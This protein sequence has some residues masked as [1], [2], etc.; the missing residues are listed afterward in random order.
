MQINGAVRA[1]VEEGAQHDLETK[2]DDNWGT[3][4]LTQNLL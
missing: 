2:N 3:E 1:P 4:V